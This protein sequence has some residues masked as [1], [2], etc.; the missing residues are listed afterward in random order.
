MSDSFSKMLK[1]ILSF[2]LDDKTDFL[3]LTEF[4]GFDPADVFKKLAPKLT[5]AKSKRLLQY[6]IVFGLTRG[7]GGNKSF[8]MLS[9]RTKSA[10]GKSMLN[11]A[12]ALFNIVV[13]RTKTK[14]DVTIDRVMAAFPSVTHAVWVSICDKDNCPDKFDDYEGDLPN[15]LQYPGSPA[16][17][18]DK[19]HTKYFDEYCN[20]MQG[21]QEIWGRNGNVKGGKQ[22]RE[23]VERFA[24]LQY[25]S[26]LFPLDKRPTYE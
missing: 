13:T 15:E 14:D 6:V 3:E 11:D 24:E 19:T 16:A 7:F 17:M 9:E 21:L 22:S 18:S 8:E 4:S 25:N 10:S 26:K 20:W 23:V 2:K 1:E 5:D 12:R